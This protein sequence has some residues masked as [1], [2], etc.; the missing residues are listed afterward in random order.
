MLETISYSRFRNS[1][2]ECLRDCSQLGRRFV[3]TREDEPEAV[4]ISMEEW[5]AITETLSILSNSTLMQ[6]IMKSQKDIKKSDVRPAED[7][8]RELLK[9]D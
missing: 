1:L 2:S 9:D 8:F 6:Q 4:V 3:V 5:K 7:V